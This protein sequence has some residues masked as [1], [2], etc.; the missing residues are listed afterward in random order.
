MHQSM[1]LAT[2]AMAGLSAAQVVTMHLPAWGESKPVGSVISS[3]KDKATYAMTCADT[4]TTAFCPF[5]KNFRV[6]SAPSTIIFSQTMEAEGSLLASASLK[7]ASEVL[8]I[9]CS[10]T[11]EATLSC[12]GSMK[13]MSG[14]STITATTVEDTA[15]DATS[16]LVAV[17]MTDRLPG[18]TGAAAPAPTG[19]GASG[20]AT[21]NS[22]PSSTTTST[23]RNA[24][25]RATQN[26]VLAGVAALVGGAAML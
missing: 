21:G 24:G 19:T 23:S 17:T 26:A 2:A 3:D 9:T 1:L 22:N 4:A 8:D 18:A 16:F 15:T 20:S 10:S 7:S 6:T 13:L 11:N 5:G 12:T 25:P 14:S